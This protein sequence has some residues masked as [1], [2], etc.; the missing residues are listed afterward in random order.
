MFAVCPLPDGQC[1]IV[2]LDDDPS[3]AMEEKGTA[4]E[5]AFLDILRR[6]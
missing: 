4:A 1:E 3:A 6:F 5:H 2:G